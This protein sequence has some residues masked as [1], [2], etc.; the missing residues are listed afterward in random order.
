[1][2]PTCNCPKLCQVLQLL[3]ILSGSQG[4]PVKQLVQCVSGR[5]FNIHCI[6]D[7]DSQGSR[8]SNS[9]LMMG[10]TAQ[11]AHA[12]ARNSRSLPHPCPQRLKKGPKMYMSVTTIWLKDLRLLTAEAV[13][14]IPRA[15]LQGGNCWLPADKLRSQYLLPALHPPWHHLPSLPTA[16]WALTPG[17]FPL[18]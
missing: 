14:V 17:C 6:S 12:T 9:A 4:C 18:A 3:S 11:Q 16:I 1:M 13:L 10:Q 5:L 2:S 7:G 15:T 8:L